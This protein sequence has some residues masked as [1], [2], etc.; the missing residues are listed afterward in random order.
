MRPTLIVSGGQTGADRGGLDAAI[1]LG[2][3]H[4]GW[5]P[6]GRR[7]EDGRIPARYALRESESTRYAERTAQNVRDSD[8]TAL[9]T[10]GPPTGGS[11]LTLA[12]ARRDGRPILHVDLAH[13][14]EAAA[15]TALADWLR[16]TCPSV[17]NVAGSRESASP[18]MQATVARI[19]RAALI[20]A[21][22]I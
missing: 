14:D 16:H 8:A 22:A 17:L 18:G 5:C 9:F 15:A 13:L 19:V 2:I 21:D 4:G 12:I 7:A 10:H 11:A 3:P 6:R 20:A 1:A